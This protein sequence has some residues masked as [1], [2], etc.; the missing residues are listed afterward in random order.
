[1][2]GHDMEDADLCELVGALGQLLGDVLKAK[3]CLRMLNWPG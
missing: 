1:M 2:A 3:R